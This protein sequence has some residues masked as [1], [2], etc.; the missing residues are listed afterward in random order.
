MEH[1]LGQRQSSLWHA[2]KVD[3]LLSRDTDQERLRISRDTKIPFPTYR[4]VI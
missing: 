3:R 1:R 4:N 2:D